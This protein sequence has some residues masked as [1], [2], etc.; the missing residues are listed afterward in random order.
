[1]TL[2]PQRV[3]AAGDLPE[4]EPPEFTGGPPA[5]PPPSSSPGETFPTTGLP[6]DT[7]FRTAFDTALGAAFDRLPV[8]SAGSRARPLVEGAG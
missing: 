7:K 5:E 6:L 8:T 4:R 1:M 3:G 2:P